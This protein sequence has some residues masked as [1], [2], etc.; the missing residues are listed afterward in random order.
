M[1]SFTTADISHGET[2]ATVG[3]REDPDGRTYR[4]RTRDG[5]EV[6]LRE[7]N[8]GSLRLALPTGPGER[9]EFGADQPALTGRRLRGQGSWGVWI[10]V[11]LSA[12]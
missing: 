8:D 10:K 6:R 4:I 5:G 12:R 2:T 9:W 11:R 3:F 7:H 1:T